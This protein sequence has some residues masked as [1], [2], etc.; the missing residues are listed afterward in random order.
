MKLCHGNVSRGLSR[1]SGERALVS[2]CS[3][4]L[5]TCVGS[6]MIRPV[7]GSRMDERCVG[8]VCCWC[9]WSLRRFLRWI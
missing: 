5:L 2:S 3:I 6:L 8:A 4:L 1:A 7:I 9:F